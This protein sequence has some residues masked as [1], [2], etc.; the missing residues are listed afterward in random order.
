MGLVKRI[1][2]YKNLGRR[3]FLSFACKSMLGSLAVP[4]MAHIV[5]TRKSL[6]HGNKPNIIFILADDLGYG[7]LGCYGCPDIRTPN[8]DELAQQ[9]VRFTQFYANGP[10]CTPTRTALLT[11][12]YQQRVGGL[13][14]AIGVGNVGRYDD[15]IRLAKRG[16]LGLP[17]RYSVLPRVLKRAGYTSVIFGKWHL[18]YEP[19]FNP[20]RHGFDQS[21]GILGGNADYFMHTEASGMPVLF[22][23]EKPAKR[24]G[25][26]THLFTDEAVE[27]IKKEKGGSFFLYVPFTTPHSPFQG[28]NDFTGQLISEDTW[29]RGTRAI[30]I[31]MVEDM[32]EQ[33]GRIL[34]AVNEVGIKENTV[35]IFASD[36]GG[37]QLARNAPF[38]GRKGG[39]FEGGIR[40]PLIVR[41]PGR[42]KAST[43]SNQVSITMDLTAS[44]IRIA[45]AQEPKAPML[46]GIDIIEHVERE[47]QERPRTLFWRARRGERTWKAVRE[48]AMKY[49]KRIED[50]AVKE[51]LFNLASDPEEK[52]NLIEKNREDTDR[53]KQLLATWEMDVQP[54]R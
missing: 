20:I 25:Y 38:S 39:L 13:E 16:D 32:D 10:E 51:W 14:C 21:F 28:P 7:D 41:W 30:Y 31:K 44:I 50:S 49:I 26:L 48:G 47:L 17:V 36:N 9:G 46:D 15:A 27:F 5:C 53:L 2:G 37:A 40:V 33:I 8:V 18:G 43:V 3:E 35:V 12:R 24:S 23:D 52:Q 34:L 29:N 19:K 4:F 1:T 6:I 54:E 45:E 11:G 22:L 42:I